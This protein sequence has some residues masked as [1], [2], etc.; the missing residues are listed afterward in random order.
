[1]KQFPP[2][3]DFSSNVIDLHD[4]K[5]FSTYVCVCVCVCEEGE[6][7]GVG[8]DLGYF[9]R[10]YQ[11]FQVQRIRVARFHVSQI[12][13]QNTTDRLLIMIKKSDGLIN[14]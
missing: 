4:L 3:E 9:F 6:R 5:Y 10:S 2:F 8:R 12:T 1:M 14:A 11:E 13:P 7:V